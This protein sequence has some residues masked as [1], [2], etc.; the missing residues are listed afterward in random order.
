MDTIDR[1]KPNL[2]AQFSAPL[3]SVP[4]LAPASPTD[5]A[6]PPTLQVNPKV[7]LRGLGRHWWRIFLLCLVVSAPL[8]TLIWFYIQPTYEASSLL[9]I[10]PAEPEVYG[11]I[12]SGTGDGR[13]VSY[14]QT[15]ATLIKSKRV[16]EPAIASSLVVTLPL[17]KQSSDPMTDLQR[18]LS[19]GIIDE[20]NLIRV[21]LELPD[22]SQ[23]ATIVN[24][25]VQSYLEDA[26]E[27]NRGANKD[28]REVLDRQLD[29]LR[30]EIS[31]K[32]TELKDLLKRGRVAI[33]KPD[34]RLN[35]KSENDPAEPTFKSPSDDLV[36]RT[37]AEMMETDLARIET[38]AALDVMQ[39]ASQAE[40]EQRSQEVDEQREDRIVEEFEKDS[41]VT[42]LRGDI[43]NLLK[44]IDHLKQTVRKSNDQSLLAAKNEYDRLLKKYESLWNKKY[45]EIGKRLRL[46]A[47]AAN[48]LQSVEDLKLKIKLLNKKKESQTKL[49]KAMDF[50]QKETNDDT[51]EA[52]YLDYQIRKLQGREDQV[53]KN[54]KQLEFED[55]R[56]KYRVSLVEDASVPRTPSNN[57]RLKYVAAAPVGVLFM[58]LGLFLLLEVKAE[59]VADPDALS[60][61]V[62]SEVYALPPLP[63]ARAIRKLTEIEADNQIEHFIQRLDHLRFAVCGGQAD[64]GSGRCVL[65]TSAIS[66]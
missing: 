38:E 62:R 31:A 52:T 6:S 55:S 23:A 26:K 18:K 66:G 40:K 50:Q 22:P 3:P 53:E 63:T 57:K 43:D 29:A 13:S 10:D 48:S 20:A 60:T 24:A 39:E 49:F 58:M 64:L 56:D 5:L 19:V 37:M 36:H 7:L 42:A 33:L 34:Q 2:P 16:L 27:Y 17:I 41:E 12:K 1:S 8:M 25:V 35:T 45:R 65:I 14:L 30:K 11:A 21:A 28:L 4:V 46:G 54:L 61:R 15:Q 44:H 9:R 47:Q 51:F 59:R 32:H